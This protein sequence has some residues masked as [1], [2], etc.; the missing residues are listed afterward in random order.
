V[1]PFFIFVGDEVTSL[2]LS[3]PRLHNFVRDDVRRL[4]SVPQFRKR[5]TDEDQVKPSSPRPLHQKTGRRRREET[6]ISSPNS[7]NDPRIKTKSEPRHLDSYTKKLVGDDVRR[8]KSVPRFRKRPTD[9]DQVSASSP[10]LQHQK[11][12]RRRRKETQISSPIQQTTH[13]SKPSQS[14]VT[15]TPTPKNR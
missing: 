14:L 6:Q 2:I 5:P 8:L 4:K 13:G 15:S 7:A 9:E 3:L 11:T 12:G 1:A 10:R